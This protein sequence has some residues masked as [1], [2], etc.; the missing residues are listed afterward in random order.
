MKNLI[1][2]LSSSA[3]EF[4]FPI[5]LDTSLTLPATR[6]ADADTSWF[7]ALVSSDTA[8]RSDMEDMI[9]LFSTVV[10]PVLFQI[11][12]RLVQSFPVIER[13]GEHKCEVRLGTLVY[14][15]EGSVLGKRQPAGP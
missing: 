15:I 4:I 2:P 14:V 5:L 3:D 11:V 13:L 10:P 7:V 12:D 1:A 8:E 6:C 9:G